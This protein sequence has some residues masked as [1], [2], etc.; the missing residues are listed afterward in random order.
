[1]SA[2]VIIFD[3]LYTADQMRNIDKAKNLVEEATQ[4]IKRTIGSHS[5]KCPEARTIDSGLESAASKLTHLNQGLIRT[6]IAL[7]N[8]LKGF[9]ELEERSASQ[10]DGLANDLKAR[11]GVEAAAYG[12]GGS[13]N[14][15]V[16]NIPEVNNAIALVNAPLSWLK[17]RGTGEAGLGEGILSYVASLYNFQTGD[18]R[19]LTGAADLFDLGGESVGLWTELH[20]YLKGENAL[21]GG[22]NIFG[23]SLG[24]VSSAFGVADRINS[25]ELG[26]AG[27]IG[28]IIGL[29]DNAFDIW[30]SVEKF[31]YIGQEGLNF[32]NGSGAYSP[33]M[34]WSTLGKT[35]IS[36]GSQAFKSIEKY[37]ADG[38]WDLADTGR[39]G[40]EAG[41]SGL[42]TMF[43]A[44]TFGGLSALG[45]VTGF[46]PE[47]ISADIENWATNL[48]EKA[49]EYIL[50][51]PGLHE[52][53]D[54]AWP[55]GKAFITFHA[56][57]Q[58]LWS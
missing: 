27:T 8:G 36:T 26:A 10:A 41:V 54:N 47:N 46:K 14:L 30:E 42:Y 4:D 44:L 11:Y 7:G 45:D 34:L 21:S 32:A 52:A 23:D 25:G 18:K 37:S 53:Y 56:A 17:E 33:V 13:E 2:N 3:G 22:L 24:L 40:I 5:W 51:D 50:N 28:E 6:G 57:F 43:D 55:I 39:T 49:G 20:D 12:Q 16:T 1:M 58:S 9:H 29:G 19:G 48:G 31:K 38:V 35:V 15:P